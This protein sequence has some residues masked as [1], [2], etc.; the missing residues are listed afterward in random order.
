MVRITYITIDVKPL[1]KELIVYCQ[2]CSRQLSIHEA[3]PNDVNGVFEVWVE[4]HICK[5]KERHTPPISGTATYPRKN[6]PRRR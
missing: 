4:Y 5:T 3:T 2:R 6:I 1:E